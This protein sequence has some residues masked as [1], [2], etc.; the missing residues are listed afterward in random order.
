MELNCPSCKQRLS[1]PDQY[2]GQLMKCPMCSNTFTA[3]PLQSAPP[4]PAPPPPRQAPPRESFTA[5]PP[6]PPPPPPSAPPEW[7]PIE[8]VPAE[9]YA[10][11]APQQLP[12]TEYRH[13]MSLW[14]S[15]RV[16]QW[17]PPIALFLVFVLTFFP[18]VAIDF[19][20]VR[21]HRQNAWQAS[22]GS[23][24]VDEEA[25]DLLPIQRSAK[26]K[27]EEPGVC[28]LLMF[29]VILLPIVVLLAIGSLLMGLLG[30]RLPPG[31]E[32]LSPWRW[33]ITGGTILLLFLFLLLQVWI[34]F[35]MHNRILDAY[36]KAEAERTKD[37]AG[38]R[39]LAAKAEGKERE[40]ALKRVA[41]TERE[42]TMGREMIHLTLRRT[43]WLRT[44]FYLHFLAVICAAIVFWNDLRRG[45]PMP[46]VDVLW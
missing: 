37:L 10:E 41:S 21:T 3:P 36:Y 29:Y 5:P 45:K 12:P 44:A 16:L 30:Y 24:W 7:E 25:K 27:P 9:E 28:I 22:F 42:V 38:M 20:G 8:E 33:A 15:G 34:G 40:Q 11:T 6:A 39:E 43:S 31:L 1:I 19:F 46:R 35:S 23:Y 14:L 4:P 32:A 13:R 2:A 26:S 17:V 18:W